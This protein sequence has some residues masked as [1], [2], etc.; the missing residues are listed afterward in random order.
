M[1]TETKFATLPKGEKPNCFAVAVETLL[2]RQGETPTSPRH[3]D[4]RPIWGAVWQLGEG[5]QMTHAVR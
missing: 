5:E 3:Y 4:N 1:R 2:A